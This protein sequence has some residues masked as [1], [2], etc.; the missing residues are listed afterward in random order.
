MKDT[1]IKLSNLSQVDINDS[2][3]VSRKLITNL[4]GLTGKIKSCHN[5]LNKF[6]VKLAIYTGL[7]PV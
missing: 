3:D 7:F 2:V 4:Y 5:D 1:P 6:H